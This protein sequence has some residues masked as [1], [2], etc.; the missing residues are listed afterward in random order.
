M[1][2]A[3][4]PAS[5]PDK[6]RTAQHTHHGDIPR[7]CDNSPGIDFPGLGKRVLIFESL[8]DAV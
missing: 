4:C 8:I 7:D 1:E 6:S 2:F 3:D 5:R